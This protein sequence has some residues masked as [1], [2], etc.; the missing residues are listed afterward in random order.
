[1]SLAVQGRPFKSALKNSFGNIS[2]HSENLI[3]KGNLTPNIESINR[4]IMDD[5]ENLNGYK[6]STFE[7]RDR[8]G[9]E[10]RKGSGYRITFKD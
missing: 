2:T 10:I 4:D 8:K 3:V 7:R 5:K 1:M 9:L 6:F